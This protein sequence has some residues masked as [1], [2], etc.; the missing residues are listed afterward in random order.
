[1]WRVRGSRHCVLLA[2]SKIQVKSNLK[3][4]FASIW[5]WVQHNNFELVSDWEALSKIWILAKITTNSGYEKCA[6][7]LYE[8]SFKYQSTWV[9]KKPAK[10]KQCINVDTNCFN[11]IMQ[12]MLLWC[13][14]TVHRQCQTYLNGHASIILI[15]I[16]LS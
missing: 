9:N 4:F 14:L 15:T 13:G 3:C 7:A 5:N 10:A 1:M 2:V 16:P 11:Q 12:I 6:E 8:N